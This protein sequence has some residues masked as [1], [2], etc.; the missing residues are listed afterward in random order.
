MHVCYKEDNDQLLFLFLKK[1][2]HLQQRQLKLGIK[3]TSFQLHTG[4]GKS[5]T[6]LRKAVLVPPLHWW[7]SEQVN[8]AE[9]MYF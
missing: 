8:E 6:R 7:L 9:A 1:S 3:K 4:V 2:P 5:W